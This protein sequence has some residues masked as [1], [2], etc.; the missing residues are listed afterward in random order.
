MASPLGDTYG[1]MVINM[2]GRDGTQ[3]LSDQLNTLGADGWQVVGVDTIH[4]RIIL[5]QQLTT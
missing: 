3:G 4:A 2:P 1:Y 5:K